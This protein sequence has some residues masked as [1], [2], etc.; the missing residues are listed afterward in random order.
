MALAADAAQI[1]TALKHLSAILRLGAIAP[2]FA[3]T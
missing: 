2:S 1:F 3:A